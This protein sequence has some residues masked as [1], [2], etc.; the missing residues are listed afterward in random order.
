MEEHGCLDFDG[1][2]A[3]AARLLATDDSARTAAAAKLTH[4]FVDEFQD[5]NPVQYRLLAEAGRLADGR[6]F[7]IGDP[8]QSIYAF[9]GADPEVF[10]RFSSDFPSAVRF[11]LTNNYRSSSRILSSAAALLSRSEPLIAARDRPGTV[12]LCVLPSEQS[13]AVFAARAVS[14][15]VGGRDMIESSRLSG[16]FPPSSLSSIA[17]LA[18]TER[19]L[20]IVA[21]CLDKEGLPWKLRGGIRGL[22]SESA[23]LMAHLMRFFVDPS[24]PV[25]NVYFASRPEV[26]TKL[27]K[28]RPGIRTAV[29]FTRTAAKEWNLSGLEEFFSLLSPDDTVESALEILRSPLEEAFETSRDELTQKAE[30]VSLLTLHASKGL[31]FGTVIILGLNDGIL[32]WYHDPKALTEQDLAEERRLFYVGLTRASEHVIL[33]RSAEDQPSRFLDPVRPESGK[34]RFRR[35]KDKDQLDLFPSERMKQGRKPGTA[36]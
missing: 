18:R 36:G 11:S 15:A 22:A 7:V 27:E 17:I 6:I 5:I 12:E 28:I 4:V 9:R 19:Q 29:E 13:E 16:A 25:S 24:D 31:E 14:E 2:V 20:R 33:T 10:A 8:D 30:A 21:D 23:K 3:E 34:I 32:P 26:R 35:K 1:L